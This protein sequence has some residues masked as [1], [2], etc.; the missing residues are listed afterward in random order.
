[1]DVIDFQT[2]EAYSNLDLNNI[3]YSTYKQSRE[4]NPKVMGQIRPNSL[5][6]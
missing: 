3:K 5:M 6:H 4:E 2:T 1:M